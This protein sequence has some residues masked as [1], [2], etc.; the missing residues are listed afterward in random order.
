MATA[1]FTSQEASN[2]KTDR[3]RFI[4]IIKTVA[5]LFIFTVV[6][7][8]NQSS[9]TTY[10]VNS[11][12]DNGAWRGNG[13]DLRY[14]LAHVAEGDAVAFSL[15][16]PTTI[17]LTQGEIFVQN[18]VTLTGP[19]TS[20]LLI[21]GTGGHRIFTIVTAGFTYRRH[22]SDHLYKMEPRVASVGRSSS[23]QEDFSQPLSTSVIASLLQ[24]RPTRRGHDNDEYSTSKSAFFSGIHLFFARRRHYNLA[25]GVA[26]IDHSTS[27][28]MKVDGDGG[29]FGQPHP[30]HHRQQLSG[31]TATGDGGSIE[32]TNGAV[33]IVNSTISSNQAAGSGGGSSMGAHL[34]S[35]EH[36]R[37][38]HA[39][40]PA[41]SRI[42]SAPHR[43]PS[44]IPSSAGTQPP[45]R[46]QMQ[47][48][49]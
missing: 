18:S 15:P 39:T 26:S 43:L 29:R 7:S 46:T 34:I 19:G 4:A 37:F 17:A 14:C 47:R 27:L 42:F 20:G 38:N 11:A 8:V 31:N 9:A 25:T 5:T 10:T 48:R 33:T 49:I 35:I 32:S 6:G 13:C 44:S 30:D 41:A 45:P 12:A 22:I 3:S 2:M 40:M 1:L 21:N 28:T 16:N 23:S 24:C 36:H